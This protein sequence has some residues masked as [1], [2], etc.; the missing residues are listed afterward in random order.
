MDGYVGIPQSARLVA[1]FAEQTFTGINAGS[2]AAETA[3]TD[4]FRLEM[5][6]FGVKVITVHIGALSTNNFSTGKNFK[7]PESSRYNSIEKGIAARA[8]GEDGVPR[9]EAA[10]YAERVVGDVLGGSTWQI[11]RGGYASIVR[12]ISSWFPASVSVSRD[13]H[14][15]LRCVCPEAYILIRMPYRSEGLVWIL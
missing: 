2:K 7:L 12:Y 3:I 11:W 13:F 9:I 10:E 1:D 5:A 8:R 4:A 15:G 6:P 14:Y